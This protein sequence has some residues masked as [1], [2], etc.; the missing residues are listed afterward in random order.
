MFKNVASQTATLY[1]IDSATGLPKTGDAANMLFYAS[2]DDGTV[3]VIAAN[4][5]VPT[6][7]DSTNG[8]GLYKIALSQAET[9]ADKLLFS[10]KS[11]TSGIVVVPALVYTVPNRFGSLVID[12][13]GLADANAVKVGP[14]GAGTAQT[15]RDLGASVIVASINADAVN[16]SALAT[17]AVT[18]IR[19]AITGYS[20]AFN[21]DASG[22]VKVSDG[23]GANQ[24]DTSSGGLAHVILCDTI[25]TYTGDTPQTGDSFARI[26]STG[27][28]LSSLAQASL[29]TSAR[30]VYVDNLSGGAVAL[31]ADITALNN[32]TAAS[33]WAAATRT[34]TALSGLTVDTVTT[35]T[36]LPAITVD[37]LTSTG[38]AAS[39]VQE[40]RNAITGGAY[41]LDTDANGAMRIVDGTGSRELDTNAGAIAHVILADTVTTLTNAVGNNISTAQVLAQVE[42]ALATTTRS[43]PGQAA[44]GATPTIA[45]ALMQLFQ[46][47]VSDTE[48]DAAEQRIKSGATVLQ[49][50]TVSDDNTT[51]IIGP[52]LTGP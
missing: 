51:F 42:T 49:K 3:T 52:L 39:A 13:A 46:L 38:L 35:L 2:K 44:P 6:E 21:L 31:H 23:T 33:V 29:W 15:A 34:L 11:S 10:G 28:G 36:N 19:N 37:W 40:I 48:Q 5:G 26:G 7:V 4:S 16:A 9:N 8:K 47:A 24:I 27:S 50:R 14:T 32:I 18:E 25:T 22:N 43:M 41:A 17:D 12:A 30:A 45:Q 1:A 20:G